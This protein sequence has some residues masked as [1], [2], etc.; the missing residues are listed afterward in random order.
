MTKEPNKKIAF[1]KHRKIHRSKLKSKSVLKFP[2]KTT[3]LYIK[4]V[5]N[6]KINPTL[7]QTFPTKKISNPILSLYFFQFGSV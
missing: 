5:K 7:K 1:D 6:P 3:K 4:S 2:Y